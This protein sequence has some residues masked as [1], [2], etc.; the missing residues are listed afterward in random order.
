MRGENVGRASATGPVVVLGFGAAAV[1]ALCALR[2]AGFA[3]P[4]TVVMR[5]TSGLPRPSRCRSPHV[6][7]P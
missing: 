6:A 5:E 7:M 4:V 3:G 2:E 1:S